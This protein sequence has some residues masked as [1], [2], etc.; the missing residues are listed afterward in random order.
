MGDRRPGLA[1]EGAVPGRIG[2]VNERAEF[3]R[4]VLGRLSGAESS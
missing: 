1:G 3:W 2:V 4:A